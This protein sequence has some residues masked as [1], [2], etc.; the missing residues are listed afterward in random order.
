MLA[1][2]SLAA[3][4]PEALKSVYRNV[5]PT[6]L[7]DDARLLRRHVALDLIKRRRRRSPR[8]ADDRIEHARLYMGGLLSMPHE[9]YGQIAFAHGIEPRSPFSDRRMIEFGIRMPRSAKVCNG[10]YKLLARRSLAGILPEEVRW[11]RDV[12]MHPGGEFRRHFA[13][14]LARDAPGVWNLHT[15]GDRMDRWVDRE[16]LDHAWREFEREPDGLK[17]GPLLTLAAN[18]H[19]LGSHGRAELAMEA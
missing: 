18:A 17:V 2:R 15:I 3:A 9:G 14:Q 7:P 1:L 8:H 6:Y 12:T 10:W 19:W 11:R 5:K 13:E 16:S 4:T